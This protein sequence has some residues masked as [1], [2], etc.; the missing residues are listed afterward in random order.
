MEIILS[1]TRIMQICVYFN[2]YGEIIDDQ[3]LRFKTLL[4]YCYIYFLAMKL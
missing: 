4:K 3:R 1:L 2:C